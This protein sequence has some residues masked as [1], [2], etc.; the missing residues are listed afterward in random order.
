MVNQAHPGRARYPEM[1]DMTHAFA[2]NGEFH[3]EVIRPVLSWMKEQLGVT[4]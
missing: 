1:D 3:D 4:Q 2:I